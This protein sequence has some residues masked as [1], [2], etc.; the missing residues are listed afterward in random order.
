[1]YYKTSTQ[2]QQAYDFYNQYKW[3]KVTRPTFYQRVRLWG[4]ESWEEKIKVKIKNQY[5][6][7]D[8][9]PKGKRANEVVWY[10]E[11]PEP[12]AAKT[13]FRNRLNWG[14]PKEKAI[15]I[16]EE[17]LATRKERAIA[18][19]LVS[20]PYIPK[21]I[22]KKNVNE[23]DFKIEITYPKEVAR[24]F[25]KEYVKMIEDIEW[26]LTYTD[27]KTQI[28]ELNNKL[29]QLEKEKDIFNSFN[30]N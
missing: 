18:H 25:R 29:V 12:K 2:K 11:Q 14:Y 26:E 15:L 5:R 7:R 1:M 20:K 10:N 6:R 9:T 23:G 28:A 27:E 30:P 8:C 3:Q 16:G 19:P 4:E 13:L 24:V 17:W 22:E 21:P